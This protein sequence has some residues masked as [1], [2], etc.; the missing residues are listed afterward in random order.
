MAIAVNQ[1]APDFELPSSELVDG[2]PGKKI[3]LS[4]LRGTPVVLASTRPISAT[5]KI[6]FHR[7][8]SSV[9]SVG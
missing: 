9:G 7:L 4:D 2:R 3:K 6:G 1:P 5:E 8:Y